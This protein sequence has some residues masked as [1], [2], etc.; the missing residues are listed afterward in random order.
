M[1]SDYGRP[2]AEEALEV[3]LE[4]SA[5]GYRADRS[6][7]AEKAVA[8]NFSNVCTTP[9]PCC[10]DRLDSSTAPSFGRSCHT[11]LGAVDYVTKTCFASRSCVRAW[12]A[13]R[14]PPSSVQ[15]EISFWRAITHPA[16]LLRIESVVSE[17]HAA[18]LQN[19]QKVGL[20]EYPVLILGESGTGKDCGQRACIFSP[21]KTPFCSR[22]LFL[23]GFLR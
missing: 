16:R 19:L 18:R 10:R 23:A 8:W 13:P 1:E 22:G 14:T 5:G 6:D 9:T 20:H 15:Q 21:R 17:A 7:A 12:S 2:P 11:R 3:F 4:N